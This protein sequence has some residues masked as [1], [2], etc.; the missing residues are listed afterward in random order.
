MSAYKI[1]GTRVLAT[2]Y[3]GL[4]AQFL[5]WSRLPR[6]SLVEFANTQIVTMARHDPEFQAVMAEFDQVIPDGM[7]LIWCMNTRG[8]KL[9]DRVY[10]PT[11]LREFL[12]SVPPQYTHYLLGGSVE[13]AT[14]LRERFSQANPGIRFVGSFHG[15]CLPDGR[16]AG[17]A[18]QA[19]V[20]EINRLS[21]DFIWVSFGA[22]KQELWAKLHH[23]QIA[24]GVIAAVGFAFDVNAGVKPDAPDW[25]QRRGLTWVFRL[26]SEPRRLAT[27]YFRWNSLFLWYLLRDGL[28]GRAV[29]RGS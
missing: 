14:R 20:E 29:I 13:I 27:R 1:L 4:A 11:F 23:Q 22:P 12:T 9:R 6:P 21:P 16:L 7:P 8:A 10:G 19:V 18:E 2:S 24:R 28:R 3:Q 5:E 26:C 17:A 25:M 15:R